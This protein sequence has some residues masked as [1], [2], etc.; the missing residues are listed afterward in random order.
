VKDKKAQKITENEEMVL[1]QL[2]S[3]KQETFPININSSL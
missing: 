1:P 2:A 3:K